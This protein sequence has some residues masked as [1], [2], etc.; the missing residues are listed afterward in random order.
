MATPSDELLSV[1]SK[2]TALMRE[3]Q[4][5]GDG[6]RNRA[7]AL[8]GGALGSG[9]DM[10]ARHKPVPYAARPEVEAWARIIQ[11]AV[12]E[13][14]QFAPPEI[15][16]EA[17]SLYLSRHPSGSVNIRPMTRREM[18]DEM[19]SE[20]GISLYALERAIDRARNDHQ[21]AMQM[22]M[23]GTDS[24]ENFVRYSGYDPVKF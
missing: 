13:V 8:L 18:M 15:F 24:A 22:R 19:A 14:E 7:A 21:H 17:L 20:N 10:E 11:S 16:A 5:K 3:L 9:P 2:N 23:A 12:A 1:M 6:T 4:N